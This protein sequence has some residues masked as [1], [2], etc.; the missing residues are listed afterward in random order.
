MTMPSTAC[1]RSDA[2]WNSLL[3]GFECHPRESWLLLPP[4][5]V[6]VGEGNGNLLQCSCLENPRDGE[7]GGLLSLGSHRVGHDWSDLAA[8]AVSAWV[9]SQN[10]WSREGWTFILS[11]KQCNFKKKLAK[12]TVWQMYWPEQTDVASD[13]HCETLNDNKNCIF[14]VWSS[15]LMKRTVYNKH[16]RIKRNIRIAWQS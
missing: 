15:V 3:I 10:T 5:S 8:A 6:S 13:L 1:S 16:W 2:I 7:P 12:R 11:T 14:T 9:T 4:S